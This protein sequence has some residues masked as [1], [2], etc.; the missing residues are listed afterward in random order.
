MPTVLSFPHTMGWSI[1][2]HLAEKEKQQK[3][4]PTHVMLGQQ[5]RDAKRHGGK[6]QCIQ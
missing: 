4:G 6:A 2:K 3:K 5:R 1:V